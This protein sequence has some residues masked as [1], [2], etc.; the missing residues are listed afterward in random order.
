MVINMS[1]IIKIMRRKETKTVGK[2][3]SVAVPIAFTKEFEDVTHMLASV[4]DEGE[5]IYKPIRE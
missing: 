5:L 3:T 1:N 2:F 4:S